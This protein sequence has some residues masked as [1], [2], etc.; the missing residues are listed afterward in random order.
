M[1][2]DIIIAGIDD[3]FNVDKYIKVNYQN[4]TINLVYPHLSDIKYGR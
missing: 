2:T 3:T 4:M 1:K